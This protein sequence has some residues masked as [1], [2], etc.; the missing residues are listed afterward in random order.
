MVPHFNGHIN[1]L[2]QQSR[3]DRADLQATLMNYLKLDTTFHS[4][5]SEQK[6]MERGRFRT[7]ASMLYFILALEDVS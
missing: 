6:T 5:N 2:L 1:E 4:M 3:F 7:A